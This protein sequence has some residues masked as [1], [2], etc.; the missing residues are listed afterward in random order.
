M[1]LSRCESSSHTSKSA[2]MFAKWS[3]SLSSLLLPLLPL[4]LVS[5]ASPLTSDGTSVL[6][7][8]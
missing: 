3:S 2:I 1:S 7:A 4:L 5:P 8:R 6:I